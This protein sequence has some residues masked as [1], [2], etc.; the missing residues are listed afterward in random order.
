V[1]L[2]VAV[3]AWVTWLRASGMVA[4]RHIRL[5][6]AVV[7]GLAV[8]LLGVVDLAASDGNAAADLT[9]VSG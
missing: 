6:R 2:L 3:T 1:V 4:C 8:G 9:L 7:G 5:E